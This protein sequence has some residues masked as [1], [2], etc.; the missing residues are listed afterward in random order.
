[1]AFRAWAADENVNNAHMK[2]KMLIPLAKSTHIPIDQWWSEASFAGRR[3]RAHLPSLTKSSSVVS[4][5]ACFEKPEWGR[6]IEV[7]GLSE[8]APF[9]PTGILTVG[10]WSQSHILSLSGSDG[11]LGSKFRI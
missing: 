11:N 8:I 6:E 5:H 4:K 1:M 9:S 2:R 10:R 3:K 7:G